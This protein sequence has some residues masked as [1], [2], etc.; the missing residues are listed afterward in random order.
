MEQE[1]LPVHRQTKE[2]PPLPEELLNKEMAGAQVLLLIGNN[3]PERG[4][5]LG[6]IDEGLLRNAATDHLPD[7]QKTKINNASLYERND[8]WEKRGTPPGKRLDEWK[9]SMDTYL[10][11]Q[12]QEAE[13]HNL[14]KRILKQKDQNLDDMVV[15]ADVI[16]KILM[17]DHKGD[18]EFFVR[19][20]TKEDIKQQGT[21]IQEF[22][23]IYGENSNKVAKLLAE[24]IIN[25]KEQPKVLAT[26]ALRELSDGEREILETLEA[27]AQAQEK[28]GQQQIL[29]KAQAI[30]GSGKRAIP[31]SQ[32]PAQPEKPEI[33]KARQEVGQM[34]ED[35]GV[36]TEKDHDQDRYFVDSKNGAF[37]VFD[38]I[39]EYLRSDEAAQIASDGIKSSMA[40][41]DPQPSRDQTIE[42]INKAFKKVSEEIH[43]SILSRYFQMKEDT[44]KY[45]HGKLSDEEFDRIYGDSGPAMRRMIGAM[46]RNLI[47]DGHSMTLDEIPPEYLKMLGIYK[48]VGMGTTA[49]VVKLWQGDYGGREA[50]IANAGD[51]RIYHYKKNEGNLE[52]VTIDD[53]HL[54][55]VIGTDKAKKFQQE[56]ANGAKLNDLLGEDKIVLNQSNSFHKAAWDDLAQGSSKFEDEYPW[57]SNGEVEVP[58][59]MIDHEGITRHLPLYDKE[60]IITSIKI[61]PG[62]RIILTTDGI[63]DNLRLQ[64]LEEIIR[65]STTS[66]DAVSAVKRKLD[67]I[68]ELSKNW[69]KTG[70]EYKEDDKT[71]VVFNIK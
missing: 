16:Y 61:A 11:K 9:A 12:L 31:P 43:Q 5:S 63:H 7:P 50:I 22:A 35:V 23:G 57:G 29:K 69:K 33:K 39:G 8:Y 18:V 14:L 53:N 26:S 4:T 21:F 56:K 44:H 55:Q 2:F 51:S 25:A 20:L 13:K 1:P 24:G 38:G 48:K 40:G 6:D 60:P 54:Y 34:V 64:E 37:G 49:S 10:K 41:I 59:K 15:T 45:F 47:R 19:R 28:Q 66:E 30:V 58:L 71:F 70:R 3:I 36:H 62:D 52:I 27:H 68:R 67:E 46:K 32:E 17:I 65:S 42:E